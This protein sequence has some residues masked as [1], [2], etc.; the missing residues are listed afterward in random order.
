MGK[1]LASLHAGALLGRRVVQLLVGDD[2]WVVHGLLRA[3]RVTLRSVRLPDCLQEGQTAL[4]RRPH[5]QLVGQLADLR[6]RIAP[7]PTKRSQER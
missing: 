4:R 7:V 1:S 2:L 6:R 3:R 5:L